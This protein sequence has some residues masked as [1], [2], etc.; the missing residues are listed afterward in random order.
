MNKCFV[1]IVVSERG[2]TR[3]FNDR[4]ERKGIRKTTKTYFYLDFLPNLFP[5]IS[6]FFVTDFYTSSPFSYLRLFSPFSHI[7]I[8]QMEIVFLCEI[9]SENFPTFWCGEWKCENFSPWPQIYQFKLLLYTH[10]KAC[11]MVERSNC[12]L[13]HWQCQKFFSGFESCYFYDIKYIYDDWCSSLV[14]FHEY[15]KHAVESK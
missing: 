6:F 1:R 7:I 8:V 13:Q 12:D 2:W 5:S 10:T 9:G 11:D 14:R 3:L 4:K 15:D